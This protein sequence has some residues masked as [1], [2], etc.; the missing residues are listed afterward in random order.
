LIKIFAEISKLDELAVYRSLV[1]VDRDVIRIRV[2]GD[3]DGS[4]TLNDSVEL[5]DGTRQL[6]LASACSLREEQPYYRAGANKEAT[7]LVDEVRLGQT[8]QGSFGL[9][10][11]TPAVVPIVPKTLFPD[12][13]TPIE[14]KMTTRLMEGLRAAKDAI[15]RAAIGKTS[16]FN[17]AVK[18]GVSANLCE[19]LARLIKAFASVE[20]GVS[21]ARTFPSPV[22]GTSVRFSRSEHPVLREAA[23]L[24]RAREP[25]TDQSLWGFVGLLK[26]GESDNE[27][28]IS[29]T[30]SIGGQ[31]QVV[32]AMLGQADY[33]KAVRA[34]RERAIVSLL[35]DLERVGQR[36]RMLNPKIGDTILEPHNLPATGHDEPA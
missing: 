33:E 18:K 2:A 29:L 31:Q 36:W 3:E 22:P 4:V 24:F 25:K 12:Y 10:L 35:G 34:H 20:V 19:A 30:T 28:I 16:T 1:T 9:V 7:S 17:E 32:K 6:L 27:G 5:I 26:R 11:L 13:E 21:W 23:R 8:E 14:R 15:E